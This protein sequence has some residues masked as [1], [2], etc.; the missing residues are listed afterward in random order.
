MRVVAVLPVQ[1]PASLPHYYTISPHPSPL[2]FHVYRYAF[3]TEHIKID[4]AHYFMLIVRAELAPCS[5][6]NRPT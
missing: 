6:R 5:L 2:L 1:N 3:T 4:N